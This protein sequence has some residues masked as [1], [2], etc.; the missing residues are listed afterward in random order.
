MAG[1]VVG[2]G[3]ILSVIPLVR[4]EEENEE[5]GEMDL[6]AGGC[7]SMIGRV[8]RATSEE[9]RFGGLTVDDVCCMTTGIARMRR[10][11]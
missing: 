1:G 9:L 3:V 11:R 7:C 8:M 2:D 10:E 5:E 6:G 4:I